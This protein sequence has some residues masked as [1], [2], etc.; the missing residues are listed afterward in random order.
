MASNLKTVSLSWH[1]H[2][3]HLSC[4]NTATIVELPR[5]KHKYYGQ[6]MG[7]GS[8][9][10]RIRFVEARWR[11]MAWD[12]WVNISSGNIQ[13]SARRHLNSLTNAELS[14]IQFSGINLSQMQRF[15][16][17]TVHRKCRQWDVIYLKLCRLTDSKQTLLKYD[18]IGSPSLRRWQFWDGYLCQE[19]LSI[20]NQRMYGTFLAY[21]VMHTNTW[22]SGESFQ[23]NGRINI[24]NVL[25]ENKYPWLI[26]WH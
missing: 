8:H 18:W 9:S 2:V 11:H 19:T 16:F 1:H 25:I 10:C 22:Y 6:S 4:T 24:G 21:L 3:H 7:L 20:P 12:M 15:S 17:K 23:C 14:P 13:S 5:L 26:Y